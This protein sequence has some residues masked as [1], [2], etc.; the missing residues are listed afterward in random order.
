MMTSAKP[1]ILVFTFHLTNIYKLLSK[2]LVISV[3]KTS[4]TSYL[5]LSLRMNFNTSSPQTRR[6]TRSMSGVAHLLKWKIQK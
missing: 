6:Y 1:T 4:L 3:R 5:I 2:K